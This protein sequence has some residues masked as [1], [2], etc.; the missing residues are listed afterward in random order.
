MATSLQS[1]AGSDG[2]VSGPDWKTARATW[3]Q[4]GYSGKDFD[5]AFRQQYTN[6]NY[7]E[8]YGFTF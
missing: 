8:D 3:I 7:P 4:M 5:D 6:P 2:Y 1:A